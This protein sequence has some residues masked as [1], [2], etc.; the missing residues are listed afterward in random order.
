MTCIINQKIMD[1]KEKALDR[2]EQTFNIVS[3]NKNILL[4][5]ILTNLSAFLVFS[6]ISYS[7]SAYLN[8]G[9]EFYKDQTNISLFSGFVLMLIFLILLQIVVLLWVIMNTKDIVNWVSKPFEEYLWYW[10]NRLLESF[11]TYFYMFMYVLFIPS[12]ILILWLSVILVGIKVWEIWQNSHPSLYSIIWGLLIFVSIVIFIYFWIY[13]GLRSKF[14]IFS[15]VDESAFTKANFENN[16]LITK[17]KTFRIFWNFL[18]LGILIWLVSSLFS[19]FGSSI[20]WYFIW[21][22]W[23]SLVAMLDSGKID[24]ETIKI[25]IARLFFPSFSMI[26]SILLSSL[27]TIFTTVFSFI[28]YKRLK[29]ESQI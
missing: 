21:N 9:P 3:N 27:A 2:I 25:F 18:L 19:S 28:F 7:W 1:F 4:W 11:I 16:L 17:W 5:P 14:A 8:I 23:V 6:V 29:F 15:A 10:F 24:S 12:L 22:S 20:D 26:I 13:R